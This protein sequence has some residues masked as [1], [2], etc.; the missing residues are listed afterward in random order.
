MKSVHTITL[1][2]ALLIG[3]SMPSVAQTVTPSLKGLHDITSTNITKTAEMLDDDMYAYRPAVSVRTAGQ[4]LAHIANSQYF[5]C[6]TAAGSENPMSENIEETATTK[7]AIIAALKASMAY[8]TQVYTDM[9]DAQGAE[10]RSFFGNE[11]AASALLAF[12]TAHNYEHYGNLVTY[13]RINGI[14][15]PSSAQ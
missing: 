1:A 15:P 3:L 12:N 14:T 10:M 9:T 6:S 4:L 5:F 8:C 13:M 7:E 11:M 2:L